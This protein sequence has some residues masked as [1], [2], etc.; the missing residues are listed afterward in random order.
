MFHPRFS[1][2]N[3]R[4]VVEIVTK[5]KLSQLLGLRLLIMLNVWMYNVKVGIIGKEI[6]LSTLQMAVAY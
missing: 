4:Q 5:V 6:C 2:R 1:F 3:R